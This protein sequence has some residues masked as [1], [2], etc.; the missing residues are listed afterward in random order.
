MVLSSQNKIN[1]ISLSTAETADSAALHKRLYDKYI[2]K[3]IGGAGLE[4]CNTADFVADDPFLSKH[5]EFNSL[6]VDHMKVDIEEKARNETINQLKADLGIERYGEI[7]AKFEETLKK[8]SQT[9]SSASADVAYV[10]FGFVDVST[11][12]ITKTFTTFGH[13]LKKS[14]ILELTGLVVWNAKVV[15]ELVE[16]SVVT[17]AY[18]L[19]VTAKYPGT[20]PAAFSASAAVNASSAYSKTLKQRIGVQSLSR[21]PAFY[22]I[23]YK[24]DLVTER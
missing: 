11:R 21:E 3:T 22:P 17:K 12:G 16:G 8:E 18:N 20:P 15:A 5:L 19:A 14:V 1:W 10:R 9:V 6:G 4:K 13:C 2:L 23:A 7:S 24:P